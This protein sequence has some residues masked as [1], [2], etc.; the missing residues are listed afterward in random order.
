MPNSKTRRLLSIVRTSANIKGLHQ[1]QALQQE[2]RA[3]QVTCGGLD[4]HHT[5]AQINGRPSLLQKHSC[6]VEKQLS[7]G[8]A[9]FSIRTPHRSFQLIF[10][11]G[12]AR[13]YNSL[14]NRHVSI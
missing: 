3:D 4:S 9:F 14:Y 1:L 13:L 5:H 12:I 8:P 2:E 10:V 11:R 7:S 6:R